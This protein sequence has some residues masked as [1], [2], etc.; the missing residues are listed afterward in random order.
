MLDVDQVERIEQGKPKDKKQKEIDKAFESSGGR[1]VGDLVLKPY[2]WS[3]VCAAQAMGLH[4]GYVEDSSKNRFHRTEL[5]PGAL[6]DV[7]VIMW[8][9]AAATE[10]EIDAA[11]VEPAPYRIKAKE[12][13]GPL[14]LLTV[15][16]DI[17]QQAYKALFDILHEVDASQHK[18][19]KKTG[20]AD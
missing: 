7:S 9:C 10:D 12:W 14:G 17:F 11:S 8:L 2:S 15:T 4:F 19:E 3:R 6:H 5:Y 16:T 18:P 1:K 13:A 20:Q